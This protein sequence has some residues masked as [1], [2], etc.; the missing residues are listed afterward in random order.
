[1]EAKS[2][3]YREYYE[4]SIKQSRRLPAIDRVAYDICLAANQ[5]LNCIHG[6]IEVSRIDCHLQHRATVCIK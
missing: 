6:S 3:S 1:M 4:N 5:V 2:K